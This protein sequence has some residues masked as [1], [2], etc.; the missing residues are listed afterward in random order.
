MSIGLLAVAVDGSIAWNHPTGNDA[1][2]P[3]PVLHLA[4]RVHVD[5]PSATPI[6]G[7]F[8]GL[9]V[10]IRPLTVGDEVIHAVTG[11]PAT[12]VPDAA[13]R[14]PDV[15]AATYHKIEKAAYVDGGQID[16]AVA[17]RAL[18]H[19][20][21]VSTDGLTVHGVQAG[22]PA[23]GVLRD[24]DRIVAV[25]GAP[26]DSS[27]DLVAA[28]QHSKGEPVTLSVE[29]ATGST[30][31]TVSVTP[32]A[33]ETDDRLVIGIAVDPADVQVELP[34]PVTVDASGVEEPSAGLMTALTVYDKLSPTDVAAGRYI[35]G[36]GSL[37]IDGNVGEIG[38]IEAK[39]RAAAA[40]G[41]QLFLA[42][43]SQ[44]AE[45]RSVLGTDVPVIGVTTFRQ[46]LDA[47]T[48]APTPTSAA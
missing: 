17:E 48:A 15:P 25:N 42:P 21:T 20:V 23:S 2:E 29:D 8:V 27:N 16:A 1:V 13:V 35:A 39:A 3:G 22:S 24:D 14:P 41:A 38:G 31:R 18:G 30:A 19:D 32:V 45:A 11:D 28:I 5:A 47:L 44:A 4:E 43:A 40:A 9:T 6:N 7:A 10:M 34:V 37:D 26:V 33:S 46:A 36:T 12:I